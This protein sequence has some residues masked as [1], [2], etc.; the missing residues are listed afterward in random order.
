MRPE[1]FHSPKEQ[2]EGAAGGD[3]PGDEIGDETGR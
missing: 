3:D 1:R 2:E